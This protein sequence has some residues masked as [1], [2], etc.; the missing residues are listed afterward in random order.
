MHAGDQVVKEYQH[1]T[2]GREFVDLYPLTDLLHRTVALKDDRLCGGSSS[3]AGTGG[4]G[5]DY[6][7][8][9]GGSSSGVPFM[10]R[11]VEVYDTDVYGVSVQPT[12]PTNG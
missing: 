2:G 11:F 6:G 7:G 3:G 8:T 5:G 1:A 10:P 4:G 9:G 12:T